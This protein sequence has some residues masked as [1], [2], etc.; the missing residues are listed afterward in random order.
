MTSIEYGE[1]LT[2]RATA[3]LQLSSIV[4]GFRVLNFAEITLLFV[5]TVP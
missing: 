4:L 3:I 1:P 5:N 2:P